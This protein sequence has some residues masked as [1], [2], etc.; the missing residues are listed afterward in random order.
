MQNSLRVITEVHE[1]WGRR[2]GRIY[3]PLVEEYRLDDAE[4]AI[5]TIGSMTGA[6]KDAV[7]DM[8]ETGEKVGLI[9]IKTFRPFPVEALRSALSK[10]RAVGVVDRSVSFGWNAGPMYQET[11]SVMYSLD[12]RIPAVSFIGGLAGADITVDDFIRVIGTTK[13]AFKGEAVEGPVWLNE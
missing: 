1:E 7:D 3:A 13:A 11:L 8:R 2:F 4:Y 6:A 10:V 12:Q 5:M 9:K